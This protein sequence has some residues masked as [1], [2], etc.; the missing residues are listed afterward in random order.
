MH[1][2]SE[3]VVDATLEVCGRYD[4]PVFDAARQ[5][6][7]AAEDDAFRALYFQNGGRND[8]AHLNNAGHDL[9]LPVTEDFLLK[10]AHSATTVGSI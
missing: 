4:I 10:A 3:Q 7:I 5:S 1:S 2:A 6:N 8:T 9:F